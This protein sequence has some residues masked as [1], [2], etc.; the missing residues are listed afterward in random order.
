MW[1][2][3]DNIEEIDSP[4]LLLYKE[5][6]VEN[7]KLVKQIAGGNTD[8]LRPH[9]K[10]SK[11]KEVC[12]MLLESGIC[13]FKCATIAEAEMLAMAGAPDVLLA[14]QP[15]GPKIF[16]LLQLVKTYPDTTFACLVDDEMN[17]RRIAELSQE[18]S[19]V[20]N[21]YL[22]IN[23]GMNRTGT[24]PDRAVGLA[25]LIRGH[26]HLHLKGLHIYDGHIHATDLSERT[27]EAD[28]AF[29]RVNRIYYELQP[30]FDYPLAMVMGGTPT[31]PIHI[32]RE[33]CECSPGTFIFWDW[34]YAD[35]LPDLPFQWAAFVLSRVISIIDRTHI[36]TDLGHKS[37]AAESPLPRV[38][39]LNAPG[40]IP[41][42]QSE[43]HLVLEVPDSSIYPVGQTLY[44]IPV[45][46]CPTVA[47]YDKAY[48]IENRKFTGKWDVIARNR[49]IT[50]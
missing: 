26:S 1:Y 37:V 25:G 43:E 44:G 16:R 22:D 21:L 30:H 32:N 6:I 13:K 9:V 47:L 3:V 8:K 29:E 15:V 19:C 33:N 12:T 46:I 38:H 27:K 24:M 17:I 28:T 40:A 45:H 39:F 7:I 48:V 50:L 10:T 11:I 36:C 42:A 31:F 41:V 34:G 18:A 49:S 5:R 2:S 23:V 20:L 35:M 4:A 14:Y